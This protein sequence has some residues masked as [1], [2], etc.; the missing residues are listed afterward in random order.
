MMD[1]EEYKIGEDA[2]FGDLPVLGIHSIVVDKQAVKTYTPY[3]NQKSYYL[4]TGMQGPMVKLTCTVDDI[5][6]W[7]DVYS[8]DY[9]EV[10]AFGFTSWARTLS[11]GS[12]WW[13][14]N[15]SDDAKQGFIKDGEIRYELNLDLYKRTVT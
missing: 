1:G 9:L 5:E 2:D 3:G 7:E 8:N 15:I 10:E 13:V 11:V 4:P 12:T 6:P 14:D